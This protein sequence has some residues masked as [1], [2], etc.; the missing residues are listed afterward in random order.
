M[1]TAGSPNGNIPNLSGEGLSGQKQNF[2]WALHKDF[3]SSAHR[4]LYLPKS[5][6]GCRLAQRKAWQL[7]HLSMSH[8]TV[9]QP[10]LAQISGDSS[11]GFPAHFKEEK[12]STL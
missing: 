8:S 12:V 1:R 9:T 10:Y 2:S 11:G 3:L 4:S 5:N 7:E 6:V